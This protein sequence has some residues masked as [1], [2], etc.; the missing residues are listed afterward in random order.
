[1][2]L[3]R[4]VARFRFNARPA[5]S[6]RSFF[7]FSGPRSER[8]YRSENPTIITPDDW[9]LSGKSRGW[10]S[11]TRGP[12]VLAL[13]NSRIADVRLGTRFLNRKSSTKVNSS[14]SRQALTLPQA[15]QPDQSTAPDQRQ[16]EIPHQHLDSI[17]RMPRSDVDGL[18]TDGTSQSQLGWRPTL[19]ATRAALRRPH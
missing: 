13:N 14:A 6:R 15:L 10:P 3:L 1:M 9:A 12:Q 17:S 19:N 11:E 8:R 2:L 5:A 4:L 18:A 7:S 16:R